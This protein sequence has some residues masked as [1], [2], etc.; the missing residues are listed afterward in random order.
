LLSRLAGGEKDVMI[1][2][3][4]K[5]EVTR[6]QEESEDTETYVAS[7]GF[8]N[9]QKDQ[10]ELVPSAPQSTKCCSEGSGQKKT[11]PGATETWRQAQ[12]SFQI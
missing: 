12:A 3:G 5:P 6:M 2:I 7:R 8:V 11:A 10:Q 4:G 1:P 9:N